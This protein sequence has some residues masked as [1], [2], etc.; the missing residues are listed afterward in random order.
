MNLLASPPPV[1]AEPT[2]ASD[3]G[4]EDDGIIAAPRAAAARCAHR[5]SIAAFE[6]L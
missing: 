2:R 4:V 3:D 5:A 1:I 6:E